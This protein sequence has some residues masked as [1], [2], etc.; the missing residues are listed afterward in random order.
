MTMY[1]NTNIYF[2]FV[3]KPIVDALEWRAT[4]VA[5][6][7]QSNFLTSLPQKGLPLVFHKIVAV[8]LGFS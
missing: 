8:L 6:S 1:K 5:K 3:L 2:I 7:C 4:D